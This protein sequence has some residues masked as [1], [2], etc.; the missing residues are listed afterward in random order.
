MP[1]ITARAPAKIILLGEHAVVYGQPAVAVPV[2]HLYAQ[3]SIFANPGAPAG[4]VII[5]APDIGLHAPLTDLGPDHPLRV[6]VQSLQGAFGI[7][8][9]PALTLRLT[10]TIPIASGLGSSAATSIAILR[11]LAEFLGHPLT[12][13][14]VSDLAYQVE[15]RY[16]NNPSGIDNTVISFAQPVYF[17]RGQPFE[18]LIV[19][20]PFWLVIADSGIASST[21]AVVEDIAR[22]RKE[23]PDHYDNLFAQIGGLVRSARPLIER[24]PHPELGQKMTSN[25]HLLQDAGISCPELDKLVAAALAAG[26]SCP[27]GGGAAIWSRWFLNPMPRLLPKR[28]TRQGQSARSSPRLENNDAVLS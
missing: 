4:Q 8:H 6:A 28:F 16:H 11:A 12:A 3:A 5:D 1:A 17:V 9:L 24:G 25:Q 21:A 14:Q 2:T 18:R 22:Q 10:S 13:P 19:R 15:K 20:E 23:Q 27:A 7:D 26:A